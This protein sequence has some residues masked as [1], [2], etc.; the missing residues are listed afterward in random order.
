[1]NKLLK[2]LDVRK[3]YN[4]GTIVVIWPDAELL[5]TKDDNV[6]FPLSVINLYKLIY[7]HVCIKS[8]S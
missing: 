1:M 8:I 3:I 7:R 5:C 6:Q 2:L 4:Y